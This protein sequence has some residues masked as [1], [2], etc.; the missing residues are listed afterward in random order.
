MLQLPWSRRG[1][2]SKKIQIMDVF[3]NLL[4]SAG[5]MSL[6]WR[7]SV[8]MQGG[9]SDESGRDK[10]KMFPGRACLFRFIGFALALSFE[11]EINEIHPCRRYSPG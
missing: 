6:Y 1:W 2:D 9:K 11:K 5:A 3:R 10:L 8:E 7:Y 4:E